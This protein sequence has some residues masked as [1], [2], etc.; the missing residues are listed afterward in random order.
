MPAYCADSRS[1]AR[2][3]ILTFK[4]SRQRCAV[5]GLGCKLARSYQ[6]APRSEPNFAKLT[7][8]TPPKST[9]RDRLGYLVRAGPSGIESCIAVHS[10]SLNSA[11]RWTRRTRPRDGRRGPEAQDRG[12]APL[13]GLHPLS[14]I[15]AEGWQTA[16]DLDL[17]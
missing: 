3:H 4:G 17:L 7:I 5:A 14:W 13:A 11:R 16:E 9:K 2:H 12:L 6:K 1:A 10:K 15:R 8:S